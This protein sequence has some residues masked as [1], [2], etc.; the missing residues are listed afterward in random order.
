MAD[1]GHDRGDPL[2]TP[3][4]FVVADNGIVI[5]SSPTARRVHGI[6]QRPLVSLRINSDLH[7]QD[8]AVVLGRAAIEQDATPSEDRS[9]PRRPED[10][11]RGST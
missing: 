9:Y 6:R 3:S 7:G 1:H 11:T 10:A 8:I 4:W 2:P 5:S